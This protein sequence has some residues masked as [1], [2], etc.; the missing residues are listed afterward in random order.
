MWKYISFPDFWKILK[1]YLL[2]RFLSNLY[3]NY[4]S[5]GWIL[6]CY[7]PTIFNVA[8]PDLSVCY[9]VASFRSEDQF[10]IHGQ[11]PPS[12]IYKYIS[13]TI[14]DENGLPFSKLNDTQVWENDTENST[15]KI[16]CPEDV[17]KP[18]HGKYYCLVMRWYRSHNTPIEVMNLPT[19][20]DRKTGRPYPMHP[21]ETIREN[22]MEL[23]NQF[24]QYIKKRKI[25]PLRECMPF[26]FPYYAGLNGL[27]PNS[28]A[29]YMIASMGNSVNCAVVEGKLPN[30]IG[31]QYN[32]R[33]IG[34]MVCNYKTTETDSSVS[35]ETLPFD[36]YTIYISY[37]ENIAKR[38]G[39]SKEE[40][41]H[42]LLLIHPDNKDPVVVYREVRVD[43]QGLARMTSNSVE[44]A[45]RI[46]GEYFPSFRC[47][48]TPRSK[49]QKKKK[50][51][52]NVLF[53]F[54]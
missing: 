47:M 1:D 34:I 51:K 42:R 26:L 15:Y 19:I 31:N 2:K 45:E 5:Q 14:Y 35:D 6:C 13:F 11:T 23:T 38:Y 40:N 18:S 30:P 49:T 32:I 28:D 36:N 25:I 43:G 33:F 22:S 21:W 24:I 4:C 48:S 17:S 10:V 7:P 8:M 27:F 46:L 39:Y 54:R 12:S 16:A 29:K 3:K 37:S 20:I 44:E 52:S 53:D 41:H 9:F 50:S